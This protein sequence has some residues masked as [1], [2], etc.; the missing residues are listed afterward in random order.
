M[1]LNQNFILMAIFC[2][3]ISGCYEAG[4]RFWNGGP[5]ISK[6]EHKAHKECFE[7]LR[8]LS[9]PKNEYVSSKEMQ[10]WLGKIYGPAER[11]CMR[12]KGF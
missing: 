4:V 12:R 8:T 5:Y 3:C 7:E 1:K 10:D 6:A 9:R 11:E 2:L